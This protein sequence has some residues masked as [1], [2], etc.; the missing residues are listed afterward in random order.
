M[1]AKVAVKDWS[2]NNY[3]A[4]E[5][6]NTFII[7]IDYIK[8]YKMIPVKDQ[9]FRRKRLFFKR[10]KGNCLENHSKIR[11]ILYQFSFKKINFN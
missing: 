2:E 8:V 10:Y 9:F 7:K 1:V 5:T 4:D 6:E 3:Q 11:T